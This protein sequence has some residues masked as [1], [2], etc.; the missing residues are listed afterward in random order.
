MER[1]Y[2]LAQLTV[3][4]CPPYIA[5]MVGYDYVSIHPIYMGLPGEPNYDLAHLPE[6]LKL[7]KTAMEETGIKIHDIEPARIHDNMDVNRYEP[8]FELAAGLGVKHVI[9]SVWT[10]NRSYYIEKFGE[11]CDLAAKYDLI[12][13]LEFVSWADVNNFKGVCK[14][15]RAVNRPNT[16]ALIDTLHDYRSLCCS[17]GIRRRPAKTV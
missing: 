5:S 14:L 1:K 11:A 10:P 3:L 9:S 16:G 12:V 6:M 7:T 13:N 4:E 2:S 17:G 8:A 15:L